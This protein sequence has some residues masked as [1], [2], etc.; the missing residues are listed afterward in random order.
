MKRVSST[1]TQE[2]V[3][4]FGPGA[5]PISLVNG[6]LCHFKLERLMWGTLR[7]LLKNLWVT[8]SGHVTLAACRV[9]P[10]FRWWSV[11]GSLHD[12]HWRSQATVIS[13]FTSHTAS[14]FQSP[15]F[16]SRLHYIVWG[17]KETLEISGNIACHMISYSTWVYLRV[18]MHVKVTGQR[19]SESAAPFPSPFPPAPST[20]LFRQRPLYMK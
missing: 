20:L 15:A 4:P 14:C 18:C 1:L 9:T 12:T 8:R 19:T 2:M 10:Y 16:I 6:P 5:I 11:R 13:C 17:G 3:L 7:S